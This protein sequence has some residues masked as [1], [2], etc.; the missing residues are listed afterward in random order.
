MTPAPIATLLSDRRLGIAAAVLLTLPYWSSGIL[1]LAD[2]RGSLGEAG[3]F[4]LEPAIVVVMLMILVQL[5]GS[6]LVIMGRLAW[7][8]AGALGVF[9]ALATLIAHPFWSVA[10]P[11]S[12]FREC[13]IF[14]EHVGLIG[15]LLLAAVLRE[16]L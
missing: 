15:G 8:G 16:R 9:T 13:N 1:K 10:D 7:F 12:R 3:R 2:W 14:L 11:A 4:D 6:L 5:G